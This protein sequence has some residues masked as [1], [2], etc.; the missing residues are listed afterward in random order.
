L[1][2]VV[3]A[4]TF[5]AC[6]I[7]VGHISAQAKPP[8]PDSPAGFPDTPIGK[9]GHGLIQVINAGDSA[10]R[11]AF[12]A[13]H[14]SD[15]ALEETPLAERAEWL[16]RV[17]EQSGG[18]QVL[19]AKGDRPLEILVKIRRGEHWA[20]IYAFP[21][22]RQPGRIRG[23]GAIPVRDPA[24]ERTAVRAARRLPEAEVV[25]E[26]ARR[27]TAAVERE[28]FSGV[29]LVATG[30]RTLFHRAYGLADRSWR[31]RNQ[32]DTKFNLASMNKMFTAVAI[33]QLIEAGKLRFEDTLARVLPEYP[34]RG[35]A[36]RITI[37]HLLSHSAGL[38]TLFD[39]AGFDRRK[40]YRASAD[41]FPLFAAE[42]LLFQPGT[43]SAYS[44]EGYVVLGAV[45]EQLSG[46]SYFDYVRERIF[47]PLGM[48]DTES[49]AIDDVVP[50][51]AVGYARFEDDPLG[52]GP[53][54]PNWIF[55]QWKGSAAGGGYSTTGD[56]LRF[57][58]G[59]QQGRV[60]RAGL[61]DTL[62][63][64]H[65]DGGWYGYGFGIQDVGGKQVRGHGGGGPGSG[66]GAELGWFVDGS[67]TAIV[68]GNYDF[69]GASAIYRELIAFL[70]RQ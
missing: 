44:N 53:R 16:A 39:R 29:V 55:L 67:Y 35:A 11:V 38:G 5:L 69:P 7:S 58:R 15:A 33:G 13:A 40:R 54:R 56:L 34:N 17:A 23:Y 26:I 43:A 52:I 3:P 46:M 14:L 19:E 21:D 65:A 37:A 12:L 57:V 9:V 36:R 24:I 6:A 63:A 47:Q 50:N 68:L 51:L 18:L 10:A 4:L 31:I 59:L 61:V 70:A 8:H 62:L 27:V 1:N 42:S 45:I 2:A 64:P 66:I 49:Y 25:E 20:R 41:Y 48:S 30:D 22:D 60:L 28:E 32:L